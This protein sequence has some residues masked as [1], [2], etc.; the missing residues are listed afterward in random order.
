[1]VCGGDGRWEEE[2]ERKEMCT[3]L[4]R[5]VTRQQ[6]HVYLFLIQLS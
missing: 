2:Y 3:E 5:D 1:M 4:K 6:K